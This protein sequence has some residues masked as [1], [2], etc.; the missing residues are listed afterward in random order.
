MIAALDFPFEIPVGDLSGLI[1][2]GTERE[3]RATRE[4]LRSVE[5]YRLIMMPRKSCPPRVFF[6]LVFV[7]MYIGF[8][9]VPSIILRIQLRTVVS[10]CIP[11]CNRY[12][13]SFRCAP[14]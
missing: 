5:M 8:A 3:T 9:V 4:R 12:D 1:V 10:V 14:T 7:Y 2:S 13:L 11:E 6:F